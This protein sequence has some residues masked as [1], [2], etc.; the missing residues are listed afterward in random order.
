MGLYQ[1][2]LRISIYNTTYMQMTHA[3]VYKPENNQEYLISTHH[4]SYGRLTSPP[5]P[6]GKK[7][8]C[9]GGDFSPYVGLFSHMGSLF[10]F[11]GSLFF[12]M[13]GPFLH[14]KGTCFPYGEPFAGLSPL[15]KFQRRPS[16]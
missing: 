9:G 15:Q 1:C 2:F 3:I 11:M 14:V 10:F 13:E 5:P 7:Y 4:C 16:L 6:P 8:L 12:F